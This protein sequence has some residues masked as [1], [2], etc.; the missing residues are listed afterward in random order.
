MM[1]RKAKRRRKKRR[2][3]RRTK[4][5]RKIRRTKKTKQAKDDSDS[6]DDKGSDKSDDDQETKYGDDACKG[7]VTDMVAW[8]EKQGKLTPSVLFD[9]LRPLQVTLRFDNSLR[10]YVVL[11]VLFKDGLMKADG[12]TANKAII[13][14]FITNGNVDFPDWIWGFDAFLD[15][16]PQSVKGYPMV[17]KALYDEDLAEES[18]ILKHY[19]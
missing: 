8:S 19:R 15:A 10:M 3:P 2:R 16:N 18:S 14:H 9:E 5:T 4:R 7:L 13:K 11:S 17:L 12:V 6:D 1:T